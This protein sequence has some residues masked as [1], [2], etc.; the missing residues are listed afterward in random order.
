MNKPHLIHSAWGPASGAVCGDCFTVKAEPYHVIVVGTAEYGG[1]DKLPESKR[2]CVE[3]TLKR[4]NASWLTFEKDVRTVIPQLNDIR[5][6]TARIVNA[7][8]RRCKVAGCEA[9][10]VTREGLCDAHHDYFLG[11]SQT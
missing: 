9:D 4:L 3:R 1:V 7:A 11:K 2:L 8:L 5:D 10:R 6:G